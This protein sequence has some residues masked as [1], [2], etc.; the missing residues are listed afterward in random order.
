M[1]VPQPATATSRNVA[2]I[3]TCQLYFVLITEIGSKNILLYA[4][5]RDNHDKQKAGVFSDSGF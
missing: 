5:L 3:K 1:M 2:D 4:M